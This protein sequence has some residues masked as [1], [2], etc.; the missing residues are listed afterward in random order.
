MNEQK[1]IV[2]E[3]VNQLIVKRKQE[4]LKRLPDVHEISDAI[5]IR[6]FADWDNCE[7][8]GN[9]RYKRINSIDDPNESVV[10]FFMPKGSKFE[11]KKRFYV[12]GITCLNGLVEIK[13]EG[14]SRTLKRYSKM[15][16]NSNE[17]QGEALENTYLITTSN[18]LNWSE[19]TKKHREAVD[20]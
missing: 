13:S 8:D 4:L 17:V 3:R 12:G 2:L 7:D 10:F 19:E 11:L 9:I 1:K 14:K 6:F 20:V 18:R 16:I 15:I 5:V